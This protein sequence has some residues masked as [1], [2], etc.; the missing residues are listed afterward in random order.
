MLL[1]L[2][3]DQQHGLCREGVGGWLDLDRNGNIPL[4][5]KKVKIFHTTKTTKS[6]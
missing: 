2:I 1:M 6:K 3:S 4:L 5:A